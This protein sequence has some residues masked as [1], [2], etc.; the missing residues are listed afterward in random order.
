MMHSSAV[1]GFLHSPESSTLPL[2]NVATEEK[3]EAAGGVWNEKENVHLSQDVAFRKAVTAL[4]RMKRRETALLKPRKKMWA[5]P[6]SA[7]AV[8][9]A[10]MGN[11]QQRS[12]GVSLPVSS[13]G[14][15]DD[16]V[17]MLGLV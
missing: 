12:K 13:M 5:L 11:Q 10:V 16:V 1:I 6:P 7:A 15:R 3:E 17:F 2:R 4:G 14:A 8:A 9:A